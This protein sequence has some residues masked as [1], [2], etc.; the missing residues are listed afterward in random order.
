MPL[1]AG[2]GTKL[3]AWGT[4]DAVLSLGPDDGVL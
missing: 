2:T 1:G 3:K 4:G